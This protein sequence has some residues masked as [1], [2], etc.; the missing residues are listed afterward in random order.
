MAVYGAKADW[1]VYAAAR[2]LV[3]ADEAA[4]EQALQRA[5]DY[6]RTR[7]VQRF[8][9]S[10]DATHA[11]VIEA[12]YIAAAFELATPGFWAATYTPSQIKVLT[13]V[14]GIKWTAATPES[15]MSAADASTPMS[16]AIDALLSPLTRYGMPAVM[17][18]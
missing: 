17:S 15:G 5:T 2:G 13:E 8:Y 6:I 11:D 14:K 3:V 12:T 1:I 7:Y 10:Y 4:S 18:A 9:A 16:P